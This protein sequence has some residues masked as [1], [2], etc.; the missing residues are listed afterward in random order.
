MNIA[1][2]PLLA[3]KSLEDRLNQIE[4]MGSKAQ[5]Y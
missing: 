1:S 4:D 2:K 3:V 5:V